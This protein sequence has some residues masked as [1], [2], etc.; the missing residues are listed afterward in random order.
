[1]IADV[2]AEIGKRRGIERREPQ[3]VDAQPCQMVKSTGESTQATDAIC[4]GV[5]KGP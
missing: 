3:R 1:M 5:L 2:I 4:I